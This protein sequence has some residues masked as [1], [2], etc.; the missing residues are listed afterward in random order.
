MTMPGFS[1][2]F[3][4]L[5][6]ARLPDPGK[7]YDILVLGGGPAGLSASIYAARKI[8]DLAV[9]TV[10]FGGQMLDTS[11]IENYLGFTSIDAQELAGR[12]KEHVTRFDIP[13]AQGVAVKKVRRDGDFF[14]AD[15]EDAAAYRGRSIVY[16]TG[17]R[18]RRLGVPGEAELTGRGVAY[19][20]TCDAPFYRDK[21]VVVAGGGNSAFTSARDLL[22]LNARVT[23]VNA[24]KGWQA[25][26]ALIERVREMGGAERLEGHRVVRI[27]GEGRVEAVV[28][29]DTATGDEKRLPA[30]GVFV[31]IGW[32]PNSDPLKGLAL[33]SPRGEVQIDCTSATSVP[34][35]FAAGDVTT[36][37]HKQIIIS[38]G[39][40]AKAAL[41]AYAYLA[42]KGLL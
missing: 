41:S 17:M 6:A 42:G 26:P 30:D 3:S 28:V 37:P 15:M 14:V 32:V 7:S 1:L 24:A 38:A 4:S 31:D 34:G 22:K 2:D 21:R 5:S 39:E 12:F 13:I 29:Q 16:A 27:E 40:G 11:E 23:I 10:N 18:H 8:V 25:D 20:A 35:I 9:L 36:V 19:C 33:L